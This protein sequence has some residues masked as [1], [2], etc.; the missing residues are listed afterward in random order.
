[1]EVT[2]KYAPLT[3]PARNHGKQIRDLIEPARTFGEI[4]VV[5]PDLTSPEI[6][7]GTVFDG[8][9]DV[10]PAEINEGGIEITFNE[11]VSGNIALQTEG[12]DDVSWIGKVEGTKGTLEPVAA[13]EI[14]NE[15]TYVIRG[16]VADAAGNETEVH[17]TFTTKPLE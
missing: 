7:G 3:T 12:G 2:G 16:T 8:E 17:I 5:P 6:T 9:E 4:P 15:T 14:G 10:D 11:E 13:K 1:M